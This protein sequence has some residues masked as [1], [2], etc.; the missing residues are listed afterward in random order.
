MTSEFNVQGLDVKDS[1]YLK[2]DCVPNVKVVLKM[3][4]L[5]STNNQVK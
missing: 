5:W 1:F 3:F 4:S 2:F